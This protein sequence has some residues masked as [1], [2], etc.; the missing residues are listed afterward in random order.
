ME[1]AT[2]EAARTYRIA[3]VAAM[4]GL[5]IP[6]I[7]S[8]ERRYGFPRTP[9]TRGGHRRYS[10]REVRELRDVRDAIALGHP[11]REAVEL[12]RGRSRRRVVRPPEL[13]R[14]LRAIVSYDSAA[15]RDALRAA[16]ERLGI[17]VAI[18]DVALAAMREI[19]A[20]WEAARCD[21]AE[22][23]LATDVV[24]TWLGLLRATAPPPHRGPIV[25]A[26]APRDSHTIGLEAFATILARSGWDTRILGASTP[27]EALV[28]AVRATGA[29]AGVV[30]AQR[31]AG[32]R[33]AVE[34]LAALAALPGV[35]PCYAG[36]AFGP[37]RA[38]RGLPGVYLGDDVLEGVTVLE[39]TVGEREVVAVSP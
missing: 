4:L 11:A 13:K 3:E 16:A 33:A 39:R 7:R 37:R 25:L 8:W 21:V 23:H 22:E 28:S 9:R 1:T 24:R 38:R 17:E 18:R 2:E 30:T 12:V 35:L 31:R 29:L 26:C 19:G 20:R 14:F 27:V 15:G 32:R 34:A 10:E 5:P 6:T 36:A